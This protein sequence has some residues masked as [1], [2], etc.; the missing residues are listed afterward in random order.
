VKFTIPEP[1]H[2]LQELSYKSE[3]VFRALYLIQSHSELEIVQWRKLT[4]RSS[5]HTEGKSLIVK[6]IITVVQDLGAIRIVS[7]G[8]GIG[9]F[10][11]YVDI[12]WRH[13]KRFFMFSW[14]TQNFTVIDTVY[15]N[16]L[17]QSWRCRVVKFCYFPFYFTQQDIIELESTVL[18]TTLSTTLFYFPNIN[19]IEILLL[20]FARF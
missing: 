18:F 12:L 20:L 13:T 4:Q 3:W 17:V 8:E 5:S 2:T 11:D 1:T 19:T 16:L 15:C 14:N 9:S 10:A 6:V 7:K